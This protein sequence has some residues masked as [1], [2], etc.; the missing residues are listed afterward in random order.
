MTLFSAAWPLAPFFCLVNNFIELRSDAF[1][2][3]AA[4][5]RPTPH[6][7]D[8]IGPW[9]K[10]LTLI[11]WLSSI[12]VPSLVILYHKWELTKP[13]SL[14]T[15][16]KLP[17]LLTTLIVSEHIFLVLYYV[18]GQAANQL[19]TKGIQNRKRA[20]FELKKRYLLR[21]GIDVLAGRHGG[22][23]RWSGK[24]GKVKDGEEEDGGDDGSVLYG[25]ALGEL[26]KVVG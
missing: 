12:T 19:P 22:V 17:L 18:F 5:R 3:Y 14:Q 1:K 25:V 8:N 26:Q 10:N 23:V 20:E 11:S 16:D 21:A 24:N 6:R 15:S 2:I 13:A 7:A 9:I 4:T